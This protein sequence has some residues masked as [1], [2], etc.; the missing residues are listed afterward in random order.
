MHLPPLIQR[1]LERYRPRS[2][3]AEPGS[4]ASDF[5]PRPDLTPRTIDRTRVYATNAIGK[6]LCAWHVTYVDVLMTVGANKDCADCRPHFMDVP[7]QERYWCEALVSIGGLAADEVL[8]HERHPRFFY[9]D[10]QHALQCARYLIAMHASPAD[11]PWS[12]VPSCAI[13]FETDYFPEHPSANESRILRECYAA[14]YS[15][16]KHEQETARLATDLLCERH[17]L[18]SDELA[19]VFGARLFDPNDH[20]RHGLIISP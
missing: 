15:L 1:F 14:A 18:L 17:R 2:K 6:A 3:T 7:S 5:Y 19:R 20:T 13:V 12:R 9:K 10:L 16:I 8:N 11:P 4:R